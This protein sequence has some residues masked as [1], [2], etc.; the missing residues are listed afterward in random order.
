MST[1]EISMPVDGELRS[2]ATS[3]AKVTKIPLKDFKLPVADN[4][5]ISIMGI[6]GFGKSYFLKHAILPNLRRV[7]VYDHVWGYPDDNVW[8][9]K[10][11]KE[12]KKY[13]NWYLATEWREL[14]DLMQHANKKKNQR[15]PYYIVF[16]P[17]K[18]S[19]STFEFFCQVVWTLGRFLM[20]VDEMADVCTPQKITSNHS[21]I[22]R[23]GR[24]KNIGYIG[25]T[26]RPASV[27]NIFKSQTTRAFI[28]RLNLPPDVKYLKE[29]MGDEMEAIRTLPHFHYI[30]WD[31]TRLIKMK[32]LKEEEEPIQI[33][34]KTASHIEEAKFSEKERDE[35][36]EVVENIEEEF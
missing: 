31:G 36:I 10:R 21:Q 9:V 27:H 16:R 18:H 7:V 12:F 3:K 26:Q 1:A 17:H 33:E 14:V 25:I 6:R 4:E 13:P 2:Q 23:V 29:W 8:Q 22:L 30:I 11:N 34:K 28:F 32:P 19:L 20:V 15:K 5:V 35:L 24:H